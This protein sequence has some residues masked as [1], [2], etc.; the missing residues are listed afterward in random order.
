ML[1]IIIITTT[2]ILGPLLL[3]LA[4]VGGRGHLKTVLLSKKSDRLMI[5]RSHPST[6]P[7]GQ[8]GPIAL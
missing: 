6:H 8:K 1:R 7:A 2:T 3:G 5:I 4:G